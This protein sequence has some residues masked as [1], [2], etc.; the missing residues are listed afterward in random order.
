MSRNRSD[1]PA[2]T[3]LIADDHEVIRFGLGQVVGKE[4]KCASVLEAARFEDVIGQLGNP[5]IFLAIIDLKMPGLDSPKDLAKIRRQW[6]SVRVVVLSGSEDRADILACLE[7]GVHGY[8]LKSERSE[9]VIEHLRFVL[10]GNIYV[11]PMLADLPSTANGRVR[12]GLAQAAAASSLTPRQRDVLQLISEGLSNKEIG[13]RLTLAE[14]TVKLHV[15]AVLR[16]IGV[17]NRAHAAAV[18]T[19]YLN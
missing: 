5:D 14:G 7:A 18:A 3:V 6:P 11:P 19:Q 13:T 2:R 1:G 8:I 10:D 4:L 16:A 9:M 12:P 17:A 15:A